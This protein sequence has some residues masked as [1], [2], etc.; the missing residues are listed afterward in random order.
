M[1]LV[2]EGYVS[3]VNFQSFFLKKTLYLPLVAE[4]FG[5]RASILHLLIYYNIFH[6]PTLANL[7]KNQ[8]ALEYLLKVSVVAN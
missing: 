3:I 6:I 2:H 4:R 5:L 7:Q 1:V 8:L